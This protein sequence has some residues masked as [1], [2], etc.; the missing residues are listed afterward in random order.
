MRSSIKRRRRKAGRSN[1]DYES[2]SHLKLDYYMAREK[3]RDEATSLF[4][5]NVTALARL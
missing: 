4:L 1:N 2:A 5:K 3:E